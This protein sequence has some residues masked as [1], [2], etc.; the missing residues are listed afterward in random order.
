ME[1]H[2]DNNLES[3]IANR[4]IYSDTIEGLAT[5]IGEDNMCMANVIVPDELIA[6]IFKPERITYKGRSTVCFWK[7]GTKTTVTASEDEPFIK[8]FGVAM[9]TIRKIYGNRLEFLRKV[10]SGFV[11]PMKK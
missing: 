2:R 10:E 1:A 3:V 8:E 6:D 7:D 4:W 11:R 5:K 9:A